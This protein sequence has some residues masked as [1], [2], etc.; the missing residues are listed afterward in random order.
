LRLFFLPPH[1]AILDQLQLN[2]EATPWNADPE[3]DPLAELGDRGLDL[4]HR[5]SLTLQNG[6]QGLALSCSCNCKTTPWSE[7]LA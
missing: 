5:S 7:L 6:S 1:V 3:A 2:E 4:E